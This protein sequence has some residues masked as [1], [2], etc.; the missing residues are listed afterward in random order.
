MRR[1]LSSFPSFRAGIR[2]VDYFVPFM[3]V[4]C[5]AGRRQVFR[6]V[7]STF[8]FRVDV[9]DRHFLRLQLPA[10]VSASASGLG[11]DIRSGAFQ[12]AFHFPA[13]QFHFH[14]YSISVQ[15]S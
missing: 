2:H 11:V 12:F 5:P 14:G 10:A 1:L 4:A 13:D 8:R 15:P 6:P 3:A 7:S 9:V